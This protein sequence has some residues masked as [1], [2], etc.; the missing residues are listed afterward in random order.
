[1]IGTGM[2]PEQVREAIRAKVTEPEAKHAARG[3][4]N[5]NDPDKAEDVEIMEPA[6][7]E[8]RVRLPEDKRKQIEEEAR[9][10][11]VSLPRLLVYGYWNV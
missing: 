8:I 5:S 1:M 11:H 2:T 4:N 9:K 6:Q 10:A 3:G 7:K